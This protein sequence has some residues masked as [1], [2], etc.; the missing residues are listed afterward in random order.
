[1]RRTQLPIGSGAARD[2]MRRHAVAGLGRLVLVW[3]VLAVVSLS[4]VSAGPEIERRS[5]TPLRLWR[6]GDR[7]TRI[8][9]EK[10]SVQAWSA[11][12]GRHS[13]TH[14]S[15]TESF[16]ARLGEECEGT[17]SPR[18]RKGELSLVSWTHE[19]NG[20]SSQSVPDGERL[21]FVLDSSGV[22]SV[23][24]LTGGDSSAG[25]RW[26]RGRFA[27]RLDF[28][29]VA[30]RVLNDLD[31]PDFPCTVALPAGAMRRTV[32]GDRGVDWMA[33]SGH[34]RTVFSSKV[35]RIV[36]FE[37]HYPLEGPISPEYKGVNWVTGG[38]LRVRGVYQVDVRSRLP[39]SSVVWV[40]AASGAVDVGGDLR[41]VQETYSAERAVVPAT[42]SGLDLGRG[43]AKP[44]DV[45][46]SE[47]GE[48]WRR[49]GAGHE[50]RPGVV[51]SASHLLRNARAIRFRRS[52]QSTFSP[53]LGVAPHPNLDFMLLAESADAARSAISALTASTADS[54][55]GEHLWILAKARSTAAEQA[56]MPVRVVDCLHGPGWVATVLEFSASPGDSGT[57]VFRESGEFAGVL[58][59][60]T[61]GGSA[62]AVCPD[63]ARWVGADGVES[64]WVP[65]VEMMRESDRS[66]Y[67]MMSG[68]LSEGRSERE[69]VAD[70]IAS[71]ISLGPLRADWCSEPGFPTTG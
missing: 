9:R 50:I 14:F 39:S 63:W 45:L 70:D 59:S 66:A 23:S 35:L 38:V 62:V 21:K 54:C 44:V 27:D 41:V 32:V 19:L 7:V 34:V 5:A 6:P 47:D 71:G 49:S 28:D 16:T 11:V 18:G 10:F 64:G 42:Q 20:A 60:A 24:T 36:R 25:S 68:V 26:L 33:A 57:P 2:R 53:Q 31:L 46:V 48:S 15:H 65:V 3:A 56:A 58:Q 22:E 4:E 1:M 12:E 40:A 67:A 55:A 43:M 29:D 51:A 37:I 61:G 8:E 69:K 52:D 17:H 13:P 30:P